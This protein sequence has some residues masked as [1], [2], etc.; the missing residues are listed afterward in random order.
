MPP[1]PPRRENFLLS[2]VFSFRNE[3]EVLPE[4]LSRLK[5]V[6]EPLVAYELVFA[7]DDSTDRSLEVLSEAS[8][9]HPI[10]ILNMSRRF[11]VLPCT[12]AGI[13]HSR[14]DAV[15]LMDTDLQDP[16][17]L[18]PRL[19]E[20]LWNGADL[21]YTKRLSREGENPFKLWVTKVAYRIISSMANV[22]LPVDSGLFKLMSRR[23]VSELVRLQEKDPFLKGLIHWVG[24]RQ[25]C[26]NY[27]RK[28]RAA[29]ET[30][31]PLWSRGPRE[32]FL[33]GVFSFSTVPLQVCL[34]GGVALAGLATIYLVAV[35]AMYLAGW[36]LGGWTT[37]VGLGLIFGSTQLVT[38]GVVGIYVGRIYEEVRSRPLY[39]VKDAVGFEGARPAEVPHRRGAA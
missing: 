2:I 39:I 27:D 38:M 15:L 6:L 17:E 25:V 32:E 16:P 8:K 29:G 34:F 13:H 33:A 31:H 18:I 4:L 20:E 28:K 21:V 14:G 5:A 22:P 36:N 1:N 19:L 37:L 3:E 12:M 9:S 7:N 11:G 23:V 30:H 10:R 24:F 26:V 35:V